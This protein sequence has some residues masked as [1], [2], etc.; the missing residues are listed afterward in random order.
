MIFYQK[1]GMDWYWP[2]HCCG[3]MAR[4]GPHTMVHN[5]HGLSASVSSTMARLGPPAGLLLCD[6][7]QTMDQFQ[8]RTPNIKFLHIIE[9]EP[10][11]TEQGVAGKFF[12]AWIHKQYTDSFSSFE[13]SD[14][15]NNL[16]HLL[17]P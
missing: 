5:D 6:C 4:S 3:T 10:V 17:S 2:S 11:A 13:Y 15:Q 7:P 14:T 8:N 16:S 1:V 9:A 12:F